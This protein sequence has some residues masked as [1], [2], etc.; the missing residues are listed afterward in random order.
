MTTARIQPAAGPPIEL[1]FRRRL[2]PTAI[3][4]ELWRAKELIRTLAEREL[5]ARYKQAV[6][7]FAWA[8]VTPLA[9]MVVFAVFFQRLARVDTGGV[10]YLLFVYIALLPWTFFST[11][12]SQGGQSLVQNVHLLNKVYCPREVF[13]MASV[14]VAAVDT[15]VALPAL[16]I[17]FLVTGFVPKATAVWVPLLLAIQLSFALGV[18]LVTSAVVVYLRDL[19]HALPIILQLGLLA[20]PVAYGVDVVPPAFRGLYSA[21]NPL[22]PVIDGYRRTVLLGLPPDW[23]LLLPGSISAVGLLVFGYAAFKRMETG[24]ADVA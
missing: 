3:A 11:S 23:S 1:R 14:A 13:P 21:L 2:R 12:V 8:V 9:L 7:G 4:R 24:F 19:R 10:P 6:L 17:L 22:A 18:A 16:G 15:A 5:R 20:T